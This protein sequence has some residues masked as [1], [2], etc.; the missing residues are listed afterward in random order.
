VHLGILAA[1]IT[2][3]PFLRGA[4][5]TILFVVLLPGSVFLVLSTDVGGRLAF[6]LMAAGMAGMLA[7]LA[8]LW[9]TLDSS[10]DIGRPN[11]WKPLEIITGDY[12]GQ[13]TVK[14]AASLPVNNL[15]NGTKPPL[16]AL[17][18]KHWYWPIQSCNDNSWHKIDPALLSDPESEGDT[19]LANTAGAQFGPSITSPFKAA[20]DYVYIDGF[21]KGQNSGCLFAWSRHK[22]YMPFARGADIVVLRVKP[23]L[24]AL[25]L[26]GAPPTPQP[27]PNGPYTYV[28]ME[29]NLGSVRQPQFF[30]FI[31][32]TIT[33]LVICYLLHV[34]EKEIERRKEEGEGGGDGPPGGGGGPSGAGTPERET[35][36][37]GV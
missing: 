28:I 15:A 1:T 33:F 36:G 16:T 11:S 24:P 21:R 23:A 31:S 13:V 2:W 8:L 6:M 9:I 35:V 14:S 3:D 32:M 18:T 7:L 34:R 19:V 20:T 10:A 30:V 27:D 29:R 25:T 26:S 17:K 12:A 4:L 37:A 22:V 5:I